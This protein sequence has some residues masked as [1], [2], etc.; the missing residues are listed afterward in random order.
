MSHLS[1]SS[2]P[3][4]AIPSY[5]S[6]G[7]GPK[8]YLS[9]EALRYIDQAFSNKPRKY[10][11]PAIK[12]VCDRIAWPEKEEDSVYI[13]CVGMS[14]GL[15]SIVSEVKVCLKMALDSGSNLVLPS[16]PLRD[17]IDMQNFNIHNEDAYLDY[18][19]WFDVEH[20]IDG[21]ARACP[22]MKVV[23]PR[24]LNDDVQVKY[25]WSADLGKAPGYQAFV[26]HFWPGRPFKPFWDNEVARLRAIAAGE[27]EETKEGITVIAIHCMFLVYRITDDP[28][29]NDLRLWNDLGAL[30]RFKQDSR[31]IV[32]ELIGLIERPY[33]GVHF[34]VENDTIWSSIEN[35]LA[36]DLDG[37]DQAWSKFGSP[38]KP[39]PL[40]YLA[41]GDKELVEKFVEAGSERGWEVTHKWAVAS[42][43]P[44]KDELLQRIAGL[45]FDFQ[46]AID[47]GIVI[48]AGFFFGITGS[49]FSSTV[50]NARD[51]TGR[52]RGSSLLVEEDGGARS[53][54]YNDGEASNYPCCL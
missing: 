37:L 14:A 9:P 23:R 18:G 33:Y 40:V 29:G 32:H 51:G 12:H 26:S 44:N 31:S 45:A 35:Q 16:M 34:R 48:Q 1:S 39:K 30:V 54:L 20:I 38:S 7:P 22:K 11:F 3:I 25:D 36:L 15:T 17:P 8:N 49:A 5:K 4:T 10:K 6:K 2:S 53:H 46:G 28:T 13:K 52:Y 42:K 27:P 19:E 24:Q 41:C 21:L 43:S 50:G 47:M